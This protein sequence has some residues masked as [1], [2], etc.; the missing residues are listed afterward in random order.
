MVFSRGNWI[1]EK[2]NNFCE[3]VRGIEMVDCGVGVG[4]VFGIGFLDICGN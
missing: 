3:N 1:G 4:M 2:F